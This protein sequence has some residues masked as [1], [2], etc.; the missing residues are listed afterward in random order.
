MAQA[1]KEEEH[2][3]K[4]V[5]ST[6]QWKELLGNSKAEP[7]IVDFTASWCGPCRF[8]APEYEK[9]AA[10]GDYDP[11][12]FV[13]VDVDK[14]DEVSAECGI[15]AMPTF[16]IYFDGKEAAMTRGANIDALKAMLDKF[17]KEKGFA[18]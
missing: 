15:E 14:L 2:K 16:K 9:L 5:E 7:L 13:K 3:A 4:Y 8:I 11:V 17:R 12:K 6:E 18:K 1:K 10:S